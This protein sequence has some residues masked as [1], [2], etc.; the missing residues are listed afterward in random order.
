MVGQKQ[1]EFYD[2]FRRSMANNLHVAA[3]VQVTKFDSVKMQVDVQP[4]SKWLTNGKYQSSPPILGIPVAPTV[5]GGFVLRPFYQTG[6]VGIVVFLDHDM[7]RALT[8]G[9]ECEPNTERNHSLDDAVFVGGLTPGTKNIGEIP[10]GLA[11]AKQDGSIYFDITNDKILAKG[12]CRWEGDI[13]I[14]GNV[15]I[16][17]DITQTGNANL[18]G[19]VNISGELTVMGIAFSTHTHGGVEPGGGSTTGPR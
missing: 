19:P 8:E 2:S 11:I 16:T 12:N 5:G 17:G 13:E 18:S 3:L 7:D 9:G 14:K 6:D 15:T 4:L 10:E 1:R